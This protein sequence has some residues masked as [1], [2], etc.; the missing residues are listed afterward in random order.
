[1]CGLGAWTC[2]YHSCWREL[3]PS[4]S[5]ATMAAMCGRGATTRSCRSMRLQSSPVLTSACSGTC[6]Q[7]GS[8]PTG[9][10][11]HA[12]HLLPQRQQE[13][14]SSRHPP[15]INPLLLALSCFRQQSTAWTE[16]ITRQRPM[17]ASRQLLA[18]HHARHRAAV[19]CGAGRP[20][21]SSGS[22]RPQ[23]QWCL[24]CCSQGQAPMAVAMPLLL[25]AART[26]TAM[27][28]ESATHTATATAT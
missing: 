23:W 22:T 21:A 19:G 24:V 17:P 7:W 11:A 28:V 2:R 8:P 14:C 1:M 9:P 25:A 12:A 3:T 5:C 27:A 10:K 20:A 4:W 26:F 6:Q 18:R 13:A 15:L 16:E